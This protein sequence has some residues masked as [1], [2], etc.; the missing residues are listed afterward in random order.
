MFQEPGAAVPLPPVRRPGGVPDPRPARLRPVSRA[1]RWGQGARRRDVLTNCS[2]SSSPG[3]DASDEAA[4]RLGAPPAAPFSNR[5]HLTTPTASGGRSARIT[6]R[7]CPSPPGRILPTAAKC[8]R[9]SGFPGF[10]GCGGADGNS[11]Q[12]QGGSV[13]EELRSLARREK[14][15]RVA[16]RLY[17]LANALEGMSRA[18]AGRGWRGWS[19]RRCAT[20]GGAL[21]RGRLGRPARPAG[22]AAAAAA[23]RRRG[24]RPGG[25]DPARPP[26]PSA[27]AS[28]PG[29]APTSASGW[30]GTS[31]RPTTR[32]A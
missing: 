26:I 8:Q 5:L 31:A 1:G 27:T 2:A 6:E 28:A 4:G 12:D 23:E 16:A 17:A 10:N 9:G 7:A 15:G 13:A 18:E 11:T 14:D 24:G 20:R 21:Q 19:A 29:P 22:G 3:R 30:S 32:R 25:G